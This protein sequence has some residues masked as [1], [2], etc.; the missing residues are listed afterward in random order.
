M[1]LWT[2]PGLKIKS[3]ISVRKVIS[4]L[5]KEREG[6]REEKKPRRW[7]MNCRTFSQTPRTRGKSHPIVNPTA[8]RTEGVI[9][10]VPGPFA[11]GSAGSGQ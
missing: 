3:G 2:D 4:T 6:E 9:P 1:P 7:G 8:P 5:K 10:S 11:D